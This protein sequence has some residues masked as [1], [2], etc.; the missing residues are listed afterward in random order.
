MWSNYINLFHYCFKGIIFMQELC[1]ENLAENILDS[2]K[3]TCKTYPILKTKNFIEPI[4]TI[5]NLCEPLP[6]LNQA[7]IVPY[8]L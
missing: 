6:P 8:A 4:H 1:G 2:L 5:H 7:A 3:N